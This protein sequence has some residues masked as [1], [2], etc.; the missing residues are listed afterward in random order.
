MVV[1]RSRGGNN[2]R[3]RF[4][5]WLMTTS[6]VLKTL[7]EAL[8]RHRFVF[9][10]RLSALRNP[11][12]E[13]ITA[14]G[15]SRP[16][17][18]QTTRDDATGTGLVYKCAGWRES[19]GRV[20]RCTILPSS[21]CRSHPVRVRGTLKGNVNNYTPNTA[22]NRFGKEAEAPTWGRF[23]ESLSRRV[24][25]IRAAASPKTCCISVF[26]I[27]ELLGGRHIHCERRRKTFLGFPLNDVVAGCQLVAVGL[28]KRNKKETVTNKWGSET[29]LLSPQCCSSP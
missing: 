21:R 23:V 28:Q 14:G 19:R 8:Q 3:E 12:I 5:S 2:N 4:Q 26:A 29:C 22:L 20:T 18:V 15:L 7:T 10:H 17:A 6:W 1:S 9:G 25:V 16:S 13:C 24:S 27:G 11:S